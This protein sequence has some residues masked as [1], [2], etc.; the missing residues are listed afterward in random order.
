MAHVT[1]SSRQVVS[2]FIGLPISGYAEDSFVTVT[3]NSDFSTPTV[4]ADGEVALALSPDQTGTIAFDLIDTSQ[5][6]KRLAQLF[7]VQRARDE[8]VRGPIVISDPSGA[9]LV[10][11]NNAHLQSIGEGTLGSGNNTRTFT[12]YVENM[13]FTAASKGVGEAASDIVNEIKTDVAILK[14]NEGDTK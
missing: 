3:Y 7:G 12:F 10:I 5:G 8:P 14:N 2:N 11:S 9:T 4:G 6:A 1:Y 13:I